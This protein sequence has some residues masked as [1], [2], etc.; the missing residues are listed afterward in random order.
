MSRSLWPVQ[1]Q[2]KRLN[3]NQTVQGEYCIKIMRK[4]ILSIKLFSSGTG[5]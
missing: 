4:T 1:R 5:V 2:L 3:T